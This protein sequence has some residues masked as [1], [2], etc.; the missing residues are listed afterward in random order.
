ME[1][2]ESGVL[3]FY[4]STLDPDSHMFWKYRDP[5][6][7]A[8]ESGAPARHAEHITRRYERMDQ[9]VGLV[10]SQLRPEDA[11]Y[12][13]S[14]HGFAPFRREFNLFRWLERE[15]YLTYE[16]LVQAR[17]SKTYSGI[18]WRRTRAYGIGFNSLYLNL[19]GREAA[20]IVEEA[21]REDLVEE[22]RAKLLSLRDIDGRRVF[23]G[24]H[25]PRQIYSG[26]RI[27]DAPDLILGYSRGY[28][29]SDDSALGSWGEYVLRDHVTGFSGHHLMDYRLVPGVLL[30]NRKL[31][32]EEARLEDV[33]ATVL[34]EFKVPALPEM[35]GRVLLKE[36]Q[37]SHETP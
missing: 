9:I 14:D 16:S 12:V 1:R 3:F 29:A 28:G 15:G 18:D 27:P 19:R 30:S 4:I 13:I 33:T 20:G 34:A 22:I 24:V 10:R 11:L 37:C 7:P 5:G 2:F 6:H 32:A 26:R 23:H 36:S 17:L 25:R 8:H 21:E 35:T 31:S